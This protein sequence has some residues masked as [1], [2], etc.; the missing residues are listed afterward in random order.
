[1]DVEEGFGSASEEMEERADRV[2]Q[3]I[4]FLFS[5]EMGKRGRR[6]PTMTK[7]DIRPHYHERCESHR[8]AER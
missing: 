2:K 1:M 6:G 4:F 5:G 8:S 3:Y 7:G